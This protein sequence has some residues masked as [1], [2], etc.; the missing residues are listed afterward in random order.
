MGHIIRGLASLLIGSCC[1][2]PEASLA[3][4]D[5][6]PWTQ[7]PVRIDRSKQHYERLPAV[8]HDIDT[9]LWIVVPDRINVLDS[10]RFSFGDHIYRI[11][12]VHAVSMKRFCRDKEAGR[13]SCGRMAAIFLGN[14][15]RG[16]RL[17][18]SA[19]PGKAETILNDCRIGARDPAVEIVSAGFGRAD[20]AGKLQVAEE[21]ARAK[22]AGLW[23][24]PDCTTD[25]DG[26]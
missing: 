9:R 16:K 2:L 22:Q 18:C 20:N 23:R 25:F 17:L 11:G 7:E 8:S 5:D 14:L 3:Q 26:C 15:V 24:N 21:A 1:V 4:S 19:T 12:G 6:V 13:W 10:A